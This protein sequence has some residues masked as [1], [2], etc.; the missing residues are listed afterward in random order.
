MRDELFDRD[1]QNGRAD[2]F[3]GVDRLVKQV[4]DGLAILQRRQWDAPWK[5]EGRQR[6]TKKTG[7]A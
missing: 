4:A 6:R 7:I 2:L 1:F 5:H 3:D